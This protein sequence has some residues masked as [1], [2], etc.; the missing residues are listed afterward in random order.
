MESAIAPQDSFRV[1]S[2]NQAGRRI[3]VGR[4]FDKAIFFALLALI[5]LVAIPYGTVHPDWEAAFEIIVFAL[6]GLWII[7]GLIS[8]S[9]RVKG[10]RL[11]APM[12]V[13]AAFALIQTLP[14][15]AGNANAVIEGRRAI[16]EDPFETQ[17]F[18]LKFLAVTFFFGL[19]LRYTSSNR[20]LRALIL[21][22]IGV[23]VASALFGLVRATSQRDTPAFILSYLAPGRGYAQFINRNQ[24]AFLIEMS[25]GLV[26]GLIV[27]GGVRRERLLFYLAAGI[28]MWTTLVLSNSRGGILGMTGQ[29]IFVA[30]MFLSLP[31]GRE[32]SELRGNSFRWLKRIGNLWI[33]R[34]ALVAT[35]VIVTA[36]GIV[37]VG[38]D[39]LTTRLE[40]VPGE[41]REET[42]D[43]RLGE[44]RLS[45]WGA[46]WQLIKANP[47]A[48]VGFGAYGTAISQ[49]HD[50]SGV[51]KPE[52]AH[53]DY[54]ELLA[55]G[56]VIGGLIGAWFAVALIRL[57]RER[58]RSVNRFRRAACLAALAGIFAVS[59]HSLVDFG[60]HITVNAL[61]FVALVVIAAVDI[62]SEQEEPDL[63]HDSHRRRQTVLA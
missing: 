35:L 28:A 37:S 8:S 55:N 3:R 41:V 42:N 39:S 62:G 40:N 27:G 50:A 16:S 25:L 56:G 60:L 14:L 53:N 24:F 18:V 13:L 45:I 12:I 15:W 26:L 34:V 32:G 20:R 49:Y 4:L 48:G 63:G 58:L 19:L 47:I 51:I 59:V 43:K 30:L 9:W 33:V 31:G 46:T 22:V 7:E 54:L 38:G 23:G 10:W 36:A 1:G 5:P 52:Q 44:R 21:V 29:L 11:L 6:V 57:A 61:V 17:L 2:N